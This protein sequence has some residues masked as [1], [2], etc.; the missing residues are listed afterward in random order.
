MKRDINVWTEGAS[1]GVADADDPE[2]V[3]FGWAVREGAEILDAQVFEGTMLVL[4]VR[5][6]EHLR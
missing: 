1:T 5:V 3:T 6:P 4:R 2:I